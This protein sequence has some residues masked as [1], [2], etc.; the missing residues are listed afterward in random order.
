MVAVHAVFALHAADDGLDSHATLHLAT[1]G[2]GDAADL[3]RDPGPE[4]MR[5]L[6]TTIPFVDVN[7]ASLHAGELLQSSL[8]SASMSTMR[9]DRSGLK[10]TTTCRSNIR[11]RLVSHLHLLW[12]RR[13]RL[14]AQFPEY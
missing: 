6:M 12:D 8:Q 1:D 9:G 7:A 14:F 13:G 11:S 5:V 10:S 3:T 4:P 2:S